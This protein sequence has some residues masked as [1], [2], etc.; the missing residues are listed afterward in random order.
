MSSGESDLRVSTTTDE[1]HALSSTPLTVDSTA[2][3]QSAASA[4]SQPAA[5][6]LLT[7]GSM[8]VETSTSSSE[9][10]AN[11]LHARSGSRRSS[12]QRSS[13][14][15]KREDTPTGTKKTF[16][17]EKISK[18]PTKSPTPRERIIGGTSQAPGGS[19][20]SYVRSSCVGVAGE[21]KGPTRVSECL[22]ASELGG[23]AKRLEEVPDLMS[24]RHVSASLAG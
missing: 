19:S 22:L 16:T 9:S 13:K 15:R 3:K 18:T 11:M 21:V 4:A 24:G 8:Q 2:S 23:Q 14:E 20:G 10:D 5:P 7:E 1:T 12:K 17:K 6:V